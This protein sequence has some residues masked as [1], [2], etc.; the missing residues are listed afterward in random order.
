MTTCDPIYWK[1]H[2]YWTYSIETE[3]RKNWAQWRPNLPVAGTY[4]V[5]AFVPLCSATAHTAHYHVFAGDSLIDEVILNQAS[6]GGVWVYL[7]SYNLPAGTSSYIHLNDVTGE[8]RKLLAFDAV[9]WV[10]RPRFPPVATIHSIRPLAA[11]QG[12]EIITL[13]GSGMDTDGGGESIGAYEWRSNL[14]GVLATSDT[15]ATT[16]DALSSGTHLLTFRAQDDEGLWS[17]PITTHLEIHQP[18]PAESWHF[19]LY[20]A[21][22]N[23]LSPYLDGALNRLEQLALPE[24]VTVS[25]LFDRSAGGGVYRYLFLSD[26]TRSQDYLG[27]LDT[28]EPEALADYIL[29]AQEQHPADHYYLAIANHGRGIQGIAW[30]DTSDGDYLTLPELRLALQR[31]TD[32]GLLEIDVLH[33]DACLMGMLE[34]GYEIRPYAHYLVASENLAWA[35]FG[36]DWYVQS[37]EPTTTPRDL[38]V[39]VAQTYHAR[40]GG[41]PNTISVLNLEQISAL[42]GETDRLAV[43]MIDALPGEKP[44]LTQVLSQVQRFDSRDYGRI[45]TQDEFVDLRHLAQLLAVTSNNEAVQEAAQGVLTATMLSQ[46]DAI[47]TTIVHEQH[48]SGSYGGV[49]WDL[50]SASGTAIYFPPS[51]LSWDYRSYT[52]P[53]LQLGYDT[54]WDELLVT[55]LGVTSTLPPEE[56]EPPAPP[57]L[58]FRV[59]L[60]IILRNTSSR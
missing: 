5:Y 9:R 12:E 60:P 41:Y 3:P 28:G 14:D 15:F 29:W 10:L 26:G 8:E 30:D 34:V 31:G 51:T 58:P 19:M 13:D 18:G 16:A 11:V 27:E 56:P 48:A 37:L 36:Y 23:N 49:W 42:A 17:R 54:H 38:A 7:G 6:Q 46:V 20:F 4:D 22:D 35:L 1:D 40:I 45:D 55:Y 47:T 24:G 57:E 52:S 32:N 44:V 59:Y 53:T 21:G 33:L 39:R 2:I 43:A 25:V 50:E